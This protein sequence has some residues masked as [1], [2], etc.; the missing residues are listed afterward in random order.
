MTVKRMDS[1]GIVVEDLDAAIDFFTGLGLTLEGRAPF[2]GA[3]ADGVTGLRGS[4][5]R[6]PCCA[7]S[8]RRSRRPR[9]RVEAADF[10]GEAV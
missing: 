8:G 9:R 6:S 2:E 10:S 7:R 5:L 4:A 1:I 3:W